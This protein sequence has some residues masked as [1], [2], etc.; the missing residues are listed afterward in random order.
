VTWLHAFVYQYPQ[1]HAAM[2]INMG[3]DGP[4]QWVAFQVV[5]K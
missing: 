5:L 3:A 1:A 2:W 4:R